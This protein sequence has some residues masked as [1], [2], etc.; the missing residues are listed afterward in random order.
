MAENKSKELLFTGQR[1]KDLK[2]SAES[3]N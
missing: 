1:N 2:S 3:I